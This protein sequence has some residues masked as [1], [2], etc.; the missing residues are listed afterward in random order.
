MDT[1][2]QGRSA[3]RIRL[4]RRWWARSLLAVAVLAVVFVPAAWAN[5]EF[6]DVPTASPH[7]A[8]VSSLAAAGITGGCG[9]SLYCPANAVRRDEMASFLTRGL[10][11]LAMDS[12][13]NAVDLPTTGAVTLIEEETMIVPGSAGTQYVRVD[14]I[15]Q[16]N[17]GT[18]GTVC[19]CTLAARIR[20]VSPEV[21]SPTFFFDVAPGPGGDI[22]D[23]FFV[24][25][26]FTV[27]SGLHTYQLQMWQDS[28]TGV[29]AVLPVSNAATI[30]Q[31]FPFNQGANGGALSVGNGSGVGPATSDN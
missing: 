13:T 8:A 4:P 16:M 3:R 11:R 6:S 9:P 18:P 14:G 5:H 22:D 12:I 1:S 23:T 30:V 15:A 26:A 10:P 29:A 27:P 7:H 17:T 2:T 25:W 31:S 20:Q 28:N 19:P 21:F 24:S